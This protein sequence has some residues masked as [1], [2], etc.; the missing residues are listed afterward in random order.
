MM[1]GRHPALPT[2]W[3]LSLRL[4]GGEVRRPSREAESVCR[5]RG[6]SSKGHSLTCCALDLAIVATEE[7]NPT[8]LLEGKALATGRL[9]T[10]LGSR[11]SPQG[12]HTLYQQFSPGLHGE[13]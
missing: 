3:V 4:G 2:R 7:T 13:L 6:S 10:S 12:F 11:V 1:V 5:S 8:H 9:N